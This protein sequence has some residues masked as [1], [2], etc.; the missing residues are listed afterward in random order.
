MPLS[1]SAL[2]RQGQT[3]SITQSSDP[4]RI[5]RRSIRPLTDLQAPILARSPGITQ[6]QVDM[7]VRD[8][9]A[10]HKGI[11]ML[12]SLA[13]FEGSTQAGHQLS[14]G[15]SLC[16]R[17]VCQ[18]WCMALRF[19]KKPAGCAVFLAGYIILLSLPHSGI[20]RC[21]KPLSLIGLRRHACAS[22]WIRLPSRPLC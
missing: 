5:A 14:K 16:V 19:S 15:L 20:N 3:E 7:P 1:V 4:R 9:I 6:D 18:T 11:D 10:Q 13:A 12:C 22:H 21:C 8:V 17:Q 2:T